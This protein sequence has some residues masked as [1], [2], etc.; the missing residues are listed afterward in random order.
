M[1]IYVSWSHYH[2]D[3]AR[4][5]GARVVAPTRSYHA[6]GLGGD[7]VRTQARWRHPP[8]A[9][10]RGQRGEITAW[11]HIPKMTPGRH[12]VLLVDDLVTPA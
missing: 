6:R 2:R 8:A 12:R 9:R 10:R 1:T 3:R 11:E 5:E 7:I 4:G